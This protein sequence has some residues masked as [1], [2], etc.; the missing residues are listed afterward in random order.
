[1]PRPRL[2]LGPYL[3]A[4]SGAGIWSMHFVGM[5]AVQLPIGISYDPVPTLLSV[6][7]AILVTGSRLS[8][9]EVAP[10]PE[11]TPLPAPTAVYS[12]ALSLT[13]QPQTSRHGTHPLRARSTICCLT[14]EQTRPCGPTAATPGC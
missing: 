13:A 3:G 14:A 11:P 1:M 4:V 7:P 2:H 5:L 8:Q 12:Q 6:L 9:V 10:K